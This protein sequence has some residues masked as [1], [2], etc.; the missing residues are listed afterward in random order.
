MKK[1][2]LLFLLLIISL[3]TF[4]TTVNAEGNIPSSNNT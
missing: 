3:F 4:N 1:K 2:A